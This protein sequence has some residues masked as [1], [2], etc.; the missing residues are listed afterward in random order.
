MKTIALYD[1]I[2]GYVETERKKRTPRWIPLVLRT[3]AEAAIAKARD[4]VL[5]EAAKRFRSLE[6]VS[7][8]TVAA[9]IRAL[10]GKP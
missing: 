10:K 6:V 9:R 2:S 4:D 5:E 8:G 3:A 1:P 7:G